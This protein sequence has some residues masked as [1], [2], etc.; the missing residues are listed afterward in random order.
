[1]TTV[2]PDSSIKPLKMGIIGVGVGATQ[3]M[4]SMESMAEIDL[5]AAAD[6][7]SPRS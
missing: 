6:T 5:M 2:H 4:P 7:Q 1:M 3:I